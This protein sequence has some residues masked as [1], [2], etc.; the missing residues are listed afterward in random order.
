MGQL[1]NAVKATFRLGGTGTTFLTPR[2]NDVVYVDP[3]D[4]LGAPMVAGIKVTP[5]RAMSYIPFFAAVRNISE[6][7]AGLPLG[8]YRASEAGREQDRTH[9]VHRLLHDQ[10]NPY[11]TAMTFRETLQAHV[12]TWGNGYAEIEYADDGSVMALWPLRP[13]RMSVAVDKQRNVPVY[14]YDLSGRVVELPWEK[15]FHIHGLGFD[16]LQGY[17]ILT[18]ARGM[19]GVALAGEKHSQTDFQRGT[20]PPA[21]LKTEKKMSVE[22]KQNLRESWDSLDHRDRVAILEEGLDLKVIGVPAKD[23]QFIE[24]MN[25]PRSLMATLLR[26]PPHMLQ[27]VDRS[28]SWG[29]GIESQTLG[30]TKFTLRPWVI[31]WE[32]AGKLHFLGGEDRYLRHNMT[33]LERGDTKTRWYAYEAGLRNGVYSIDDIREMEDENPLPGGLGDVRFAPLNMAPLDQFA[34]ASMRER[35]EMLGAL[36]RAGFKPEPAA[37]ALG[38][39][40]IPHTGLEPVTVSEQGDR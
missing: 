12:L 2:A 35:I 23:A 19:L 28:T 6:D 7:V 30:Y 36:V 24:Q 20:V 25:L 13:D 33:A 18:I 16:G 29:T 10:P 31:R 5:E 22:A 27:D 39:P 40:E 8:V 15:V 34:Q 1:A 3:W 37:E 17:S 14:R 9:P 4:A 21:V 11:M 38:V 26:I 32:Q